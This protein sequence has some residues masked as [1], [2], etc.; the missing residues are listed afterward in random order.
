[1]LPRS[2]DPAILDASLTVHPRKVVFADFNGDGRQD[3]F[4]ST[5]GWD[6]D[7]FPGEQNRLLRSTPEGGCGLDRY[8]RLLAV[9]D[10]LHL[11][12]RHSF[13][14]LRRAPTFSLIVI[15]TLTLAVGAT[16]AVG[17]LL[18]ALVLRRLAVCD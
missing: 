2:L 12:V 9:W 13:R 1:M 8:A 16:A 7:S 10:A 5:H 15:A 3:A 18:N 14:S 6:A 11:D 17:S 4:V